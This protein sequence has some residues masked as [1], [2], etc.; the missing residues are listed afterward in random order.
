MRALADYFLLLKFV[1]GRDGKEGVGAQSAV[2]VVDIYNHR[3]GDRDAVIGAGAAPDLVQDQQ[4]ALG[5]VVEDIGG[6][7]HPRT[8]CAPCTYVK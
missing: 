3:P 1:V 6:L 5:G 4:G 2:V 8:I 7:D